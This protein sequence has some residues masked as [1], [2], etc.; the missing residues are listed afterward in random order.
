MSQECVYLVVYF[1]H[2]GFKCLN[3][4]D[5]VLISKKVVL[6]EHNFTFPNL[7]PKLLSHDTQNISTIIH[8]VT[9]TIPQIVQN[10]LLPIDSQA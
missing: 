2:K 4:S 5:K 6:N 3:K 10:S 1:N 9:K 7:F 8:G